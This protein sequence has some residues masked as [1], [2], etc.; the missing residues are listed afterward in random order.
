MR[1]IE[2]YVTQVNIVIHLK[3]INQKS[4]VG[5]NE[6]MPDREMHLAVDVK[7][8]GIEGAT[9]I[10]TRYLP[11]KIDR[12]GQSGRNIPGIV[13][14]NGFKSVM[15]GTKATAL[16]EWAE[17]SG[18]SFLRFDYSGHGESDGEFEDG[19]IGNWLEE[20]A[21]AF[22]EFASGPQILIGSSMGGWIS[23]LLNRLVE[24]KLGDARANVA[25]I[26][27][28]APAVDMTKRLI[29]D[30]LSDELRE[31]LGRTGRLVRPSQYDDEAPYI[32]TK[33]LIDEGNRHLL[34]ENPQTIGCPLRILHGMQ[35]PDV[36]WRFSLELTEVLNDED[37][38][39]TLVKDGDHRLSRDQDIARLIAIIEALS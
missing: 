15:A 6:K 23:L 16:A 27:L 5:V 24:K 31:E 11:A 38:V 8:S 33:N 36:P 26:V 7:H 20:A 12:A 39:L 10:A 13:W 25:G 19:T 30:Q 3:S 17:R 2:N 32:Y 21:A 4:I 1:K 29:W 14:L 37:I 34:M 18:R 28:I 35:D 9:R 22:R